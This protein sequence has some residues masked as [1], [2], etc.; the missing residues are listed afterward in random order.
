MTDQTQAKLEETTR[1]KH[2]LEQEAIGLKREIER[3]TRRVE[4]LET[5]DVN[6]DAPRCICARDLNP[7]NTHAA[8]PI[9]G[10]RAQRAR[11]LAD[12]GDQHRPSAI[13]TPNRGK[14]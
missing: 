2:R 13:Q 12:D 7:T 14:E 1:E 11:E 10:L 5:A 3:L 8:C 9:H 4:Q 6:D